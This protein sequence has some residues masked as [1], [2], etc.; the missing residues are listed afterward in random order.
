MKQ[1]KNRS[2]GIDISDQWIHMT[3]A[4]EMKG[5][6]EVCARASIEIPEDAIKDGKIINPT[7]LGKAIKNL[8]NKSKFNCE[9]VHMS[10]LA[11]PVLSQILDLPKI[12][13][14]NIG[15]YLHDEIKN[16]A[17]MPGGEISLDYCG[18]KSIDKA[19]PRRSLVYAADIS[20]VDSLLL[21]LDRLGIKVN[22][23]EPCELSF[24]RSYFANL[25][26]NDSQRVVFV[27]FRQGQLRICVFKGYNLEIVRVK[28]I[29][30]QGI[31]DEIEQVLNYYEFEAGR[32]NDTWNL[33]VLSDSKEIISEEQIASL[34][35]KYGQVDLSWQNPS[36]AADGLAMVSFNPVSFKY[37]IN[38][39]PQHL[40]KSRANSK[41][42]MISANLAAIILV[43]M[44]IGVGAVE[45]LSKCVA[46]QVASN[47]EIVVNTH[48]KLLIEEDKKLN[49]Q[50]TAINEDANSINTVTSKTVYIKWSP[51]IVQIVKSIPEG[52][53]LTS[54]HNNDSNEVLLKGI[55]ISHNVV[56]NFVEKLKSSSDIESA[57]TI[58]TEKDRSNQ[59]VNYSIRCLIKQQAGDLI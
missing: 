20:G 27:V 2:L 9:H 40:Q 33:K 44:I 52:A 6:I 26:A 37:N 38:L 31:F 29:E 14:S 30:V 35:G 10:L 5:K 3:E 53:Q 18:L 46:N 39:M 51:I 11:N 4:V 19:S 12:V 17:K 1:A 23:V 13:P 55:A 7:A 32:E 21:Y 42:V 57:E 56:S 49:A 16:Y 41:K 34:N 15:N 58:S 43:L 22:T 36:S 59:L 54:F 8:K 28:Q 24:A 25:K 48:I 45:H 47:K 50:M